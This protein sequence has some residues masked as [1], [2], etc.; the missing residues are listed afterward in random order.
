SDSEEDDMPQ[1]T[2][3]VS[4]FAQSPELVKFPRHSGLISPP[5]MTVRAIKPK[6]S[7]TRPNIASHVVSKS[8]SP[9]RRPF[10]QHPSSKPN[11]SPTR[12]TAAKPSAISVA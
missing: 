11:I 6:F 3:D 8:K 2:K 4:S 12:V 10:I 5:P 7:T 1:V 9:L